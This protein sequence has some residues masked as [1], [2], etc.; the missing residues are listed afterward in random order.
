MCKS[1]EIFEQLFVV[2]ARNESDVVMRIGVGFASRFIPALR[3][4]LEQF[5]SQLNWFV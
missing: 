3:R 1:E 4:F 2:V 5:C